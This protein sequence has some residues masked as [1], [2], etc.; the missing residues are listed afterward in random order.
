VD[1]GYR[2]FDRQR[3]EPLFPFGYGL[4]YTSFDYSNLEVDKAADGGLNVTVTIRNTGNVA[5]DEVPQ[6]YLGAPDT[7]PPGVQFPVRS[8]AA[9]NRID[10][11]AGESKT[12][13]LHIPLR[14][15]QYWSSTADKWI[16]ATGQR[17]L[18]VGASSRD[19][20]LEATVRE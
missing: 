9:F 19:L 4:S 16:T 2:W 20:R 6:V 5:S 1:V 8:L 13:V 11:A 15:L 14:Q 18:S 10:F 7:I 17:T 12:V 3:I